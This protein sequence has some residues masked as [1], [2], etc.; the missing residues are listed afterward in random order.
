[1]SSQHTK[2]VN[3]II[4]VCDDNLIACQTLM[5]FLLDARVFRG[6]LFIH[7]FII[8]FL[9]NAHQGSQKLRVRAASAWY[10]N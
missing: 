3:A 2:S 7:V 8:S 10:Y 5:L 4:L 6:I 9:N 1:M